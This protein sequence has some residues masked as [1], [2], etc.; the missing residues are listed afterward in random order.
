MSSKLK[1]DNTDR[2]HVVEEIERHIASK[3]SRP[4]RRHIYLEDESGNRYVVLGGIDDWHGIPDDVI[5]AVEQHHPHSYLAIAIKNRNSLK[6][7]YG[8]IEPLLK[9][10]K[11][12]NRPGDNKYT[13][14]VD[15]H[16][17]HLV[18]RE[19]HSVTLDFL[20]EILHSESDRKQIKSKV[21]IEKL[22]EMMSSKE[23]EEFLR[24]IQ[25]GEI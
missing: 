22:L 19:A 20:S 14:H 25:N 4:G 12:L 24:K 3:L 5:E 1:F 21:E 15:E 23:R 2:R 17:D 13:F 11:N 9:S 18:I 7:Y 6:I 10:L 16:R 8:A